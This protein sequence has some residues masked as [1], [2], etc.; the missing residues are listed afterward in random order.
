MSAPSHKTDWI[1]LAVLGTVLVG[2][3]AL[4]VLQGWLPGG[5]EERPWVRTTYS[6]N[7]DGTLVGYE[8]LR[9]LGLGPER[10]DRPLLGQTLEQMDVL[11]VLDPLVRIAADE[12]AALKAWLEGGGVLVCSGGQEEGLSKVHGL[13]AP[14]H[15]A[16]AREGEDEPTFIA[17]PSAEALLGESP[18]ATLAQD[19]RRM[20][21]ATR[22][23]LAPGG[24]GADEG[25]GSV[26]RLLAD[27]AGCR[28][29]ARPVG[30]GCAVVLSDSS[31]LANGWIG[32]QDNSVAAVNLAWYALG[33]ARGRR[34]A[35][36][37]YHFGYGR[38]R[39]E[40]GW[41]LLGSVL[42]TT[43]PG[44]AVLSLTAA[45][46]LYLVERGRRF[47]TRR[48]PPDR[49]RRRSKLEFVESVGETYRAAGAHR[50]CL[51]VLYGHLKRRLAARAGVPPTAQAGELARHLGAR[52]GRPAD[53]VGRLL[54]S[55]EAAVA[56]AEGRLWGR[57]LHTLA[58][59]LAALEREFT[60]GHS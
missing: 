37:E 14:Y 60:D 30:A 19:V 35:F 23:T 9:R 20:H 33:K 29:A 57:A 26:E 28:I 58:A 47:G 13:K 17:P 2:S 59:D 51:E 41:R 6:A 34:I 7:V 56:D 40:S 24:E 3:V 10:C 25:E 21:F 53:H 43:P 54:E 31:F 4:V 50:L 27:S 52:L 22:Q 48:A 42:V 38:H 49:L 16:A 32:R 55:C 15:W 12:Q 1:I 45:G 5:E 44:W 18:C 46:A 8:L 39:T 11:L 36:D